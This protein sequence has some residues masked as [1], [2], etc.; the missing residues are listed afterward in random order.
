LA[1]F[2][3]FFAMI[4]GQSV[5]GWREDNDD[6]REHG[7][8]PVS[9]VRYLGTGHFAESVFEN[10][11]SEFLQMAVYVFLTSLLLQRGSAESKD[12]DAPPD[13]DDDPARHRDDPR[14]PWPVRRGSLALRKSET[15]S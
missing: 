2:G 10:R 1:L 12:P 4:V 8:P 13:P 9:Y 7:R 15:R 5:A 6:R 3:L 11:E 14:A